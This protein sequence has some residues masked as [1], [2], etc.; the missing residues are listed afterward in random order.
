MECHSHDYIRLYNT[1]TLLVDFLSFPPSDFE[2][3]SGH[4][5]GD[6]DISMKSTWQGPAAWTR[7]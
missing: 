6:G 1:H 2:G 7:G 4:V 3:A 5:I